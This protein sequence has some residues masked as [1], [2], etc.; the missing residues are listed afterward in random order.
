MWD[1][2]SAE[3]LD[4]EVKANGVATVWLSRERSLN[5]MN[6]AM[7]QELG[8]VFGALGEDRQVRV[9]ILGA[10]GDKA[11]CVGADLKEREGMSEDEVRRRIASYR[12]VFR[13]IERNDKPTIAA[14][15]GYAFGGGL[16][17]AMACDLRVMAEEA[18]VGLT[19]LKLGIIPGA[20]GTQRLSR[21]VGAARAK[22]LIFRAARISGERAADLGLANVAVPE[23]T[24]MDKCHQWAEEM[25]ESAPIALAQA[26]RAIDAG[27]EVDLETG[28]DIEAAAYAVTIPTEDRKE[29]LQAFKE[30]RKPDYQGR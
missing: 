5:A 30:K 19:E 7:V 18:S 29:G 13:M 22:E 28:L 27:S 11:F 2:Y 12:R 8:E 25:L 14:V 3:A 17:L 15:Q 26:K 21:L 20:G 1:D 23:A 6:G 16:E 4:V 10:R 24:V 9:V